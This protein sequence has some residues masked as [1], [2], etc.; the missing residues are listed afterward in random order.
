[1]SEILKALGIDEEDLKWYHLA[2]CANMIDAI[3]ENNATNKKTHELDPFFDAYESDKIVAEQVDLM[4][5][6]CPVI[7]QCFK[8]GVNTKSVGVFGGV[9]LNL[10]KVDKKHNS[11]KTQATWKALKKFH[12]KL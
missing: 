11:H 10:G 7:K 12:G 5:V 9:Y 4:C 8:Y 1:M 6:G 3:H 2:A